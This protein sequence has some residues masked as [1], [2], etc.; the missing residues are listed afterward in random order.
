MSLRS[1]VDPATLAVVENGLRQVVEE[2]DLTTETLAFNPV[3]SEARDRASGIYHAESGKMIAQGETGMPIFIGVMQFAVESVLAEFPEMRPGDVVVLNDPYRGGTHLMD[4]KLVKPFFYRGERLAIL[5]STGHWTDVG[6]A[7]PG[8]F[9]VRATEIIQ[10]GLRVPPIYLY[11]EGTLDQGVLDL[12]LANMRGPE[13]RLGDL[14]AQLAALNVGEQRLTAFVD[15]YGKD[16]VTACVEE[17]LSRSE[18]Q[19]RSYLGDLPDGSYAF[20][21]CLDS[22]GRSDDPITVALDMEVSGTNIT[23]DFSRSSAPVQGPL[24]SA[25]SATT[26]AVYLAIK[27]VIPEVPINAGCFEPV[28]VVASD[29]V[30]LNAKYPKAVSGS[31]AEVSLRVV[32][33]VLGCMAQALP[34]RVPAACFGTVANFTISGHDPL[35]DKSYVMFRFSGGG[36]GGHPETDGLTNGSAPISSARTS[37]VE[38]LEQL[39][40]VRFDHYRIREGSAGAGERSGGF[41]MSFQVRL[42]RGEGVSSV[43]ADRGR[44]PP[45]GLH[46]GCPAAPTEV[47][48]E[49][50]GVEYRP[51]HVTKDEGIEMLPGDTARISTG[52]GGGFGDPLG[53]EPGA[54][55]RDIRMGL[56]SENH[57]REVYGVAVG[58]SE[59]GDV[60]LDERETLVLRARLSGKPLTS[61]EPTTPDR[62]L[63]EEGVTP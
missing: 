22:D 53:R 26:A 18:R 52:G 17:L 46:G 9:G 8:G 38:V 48:Y 29:E 36:Y 41:G 45:Y 59:E 63:K 35:K 32:D 25:I 13:E 20:E 15:K 27:H 3:M 5:A 39:Y 47:V 57:A 44:F 34:G 61:E 10:E 21:T 28:T 56:V 60:E 50:E 4:I 43:L 23:F 11:R 49:L 42:L 51:S 37:P 2:M 24:N 30:F 19:M 14:K 31:S 62:E 33:A 6:G 7:V 54:V 40:P 58:R 1:S 16:T 12:M 55:V